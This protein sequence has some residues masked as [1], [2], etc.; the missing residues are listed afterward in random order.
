MRHIEHVPSDN[1]KHS[2]ARIPGR[3]RTLREAAELLQALRI[4]YQSL[5]LERRQKVKQV[6]CQMSESQRR[7]GAL[8]FERV[9]PAVESRTN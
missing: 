8:M 1:P 3:L 4:G 5:P 6:M 7:S 9:Q 2:V